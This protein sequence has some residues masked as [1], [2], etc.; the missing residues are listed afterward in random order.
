MNIIILQEQTRYS[1]DYLRK[2]T[3][4]CEKDLSKVLKILQ[5]N[6][7]LKFLKNENIEDLKRLLDLDDVSDEEIQNNPK[8]YVFRYV[9]II[10]VQDCILF[11]Y[12]K[13][14]KNIQNDKDNNY[15]KF[16]QILNVI[17]KY[18]SKNNHKNKKQNLGEYLN[19]TKNFNFL[20]FTF[21]CVKKYYDFGIYKNEKN[22]ISLNGEGEILWDKSINENIA[23]IQNNIPIY[24]DFY[25]IHETYEDN[26]ISRLHR[27]ILTECC[28][29]LND[30]FIILDYDIINISN[31][32]IET[33]GEI[34]YL[35]YIVE[36]EYRQQFVT[37]KLEVLDLLSN[38]I[39]RKNTYS[40]DSDISFFGTTSFNLIW[41]E[42]CAKVL[43]NC[44][45]KKLS[46]LNMLC[47]SDKDKNMQLKDL[48][49]N[50]DWYDNQFE[51][52]QNKGNKLKPD[53]VTLKT[54]DNDK[55]ISIYDAKYYNFMFK[56][57]KVV[58]N[59]GVADV[60]KQHLY[61]II[62]RKIALKRNLNFDENAFIFPNDNDDE[63]KGIEYGNVKY[64]IFD[65]MKTPLSNIKLIGMPCTYMFSKYLSD[66]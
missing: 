17:Q 28:E 38:Y 66:N 41:E 35:N 15:V 26:I 44:L 6:N 64:D 42:V 53:L 61:E 2:E 19:G 54:I 37:W 7:M 24:L 30:L 16:K 18:N 9:G 3:N 32:E 60:T 4:L 27:C 23:F 25:R 59:P 14:I 1:F 45:D 34:D 48:I 52:M 39:N 11:I 58:N 47:D 13:Y 12:P 20:A 65:D 49:P 46:D 56:D 33:F 40:N 10:Y 5:L 55:Y 29:K 62:F 51:K 8:A 31:E 63:I 21:E 36:S 43:N 57:G 50:L 22:Q